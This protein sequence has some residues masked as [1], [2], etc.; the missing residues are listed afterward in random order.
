MPASGMH[1]RADIIDASR[2]FSRVMHASRAMASIKFGS[3]LNML[4]RRCRWRL[5]RWL[6]MA[7]PFVAEKVTKGPTT[8]FH[9]TADRGTHVL[10]R[11]P[12]PSTKF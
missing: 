6:L 3:T 7:R 11:N 12:F 4:I 8:D 5:W 9:G 1:H 10:S 2:E